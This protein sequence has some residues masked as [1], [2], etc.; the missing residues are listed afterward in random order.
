MAGVFVRNPRLT[1]LTLGLIV[2]AGLGALATMPRQEDPTLTRRFGV[3][4][5]YWPGASAARVESLVTERIEQRLQELHEIAELDSLSRTGV[6]VV[7]MDLAD[8]YGEADVDEIWSKVRDRL[9]DAQR[10][11]PPGALAPEFED[12]TTTALTLLVGFAWEGE[13]KAPVALLSRLAEELEN[14][15]RNLPGTK[16]TELFGEAEEEIR[17]TVDPA[18]LASVGLAARDVAAAVARADSKQPA[19]AVRGA[20]DLMLEV[21]GALESL[22]RVRDVPLRHADGRTLRV[23]DLAAVEKTVREPAAT[24]AWLDGRRGV[25]IGVTMEPEQR[26]DRWAG[27]ARAVVEAF[28]AEVPPGVRFSIV[29]DQSRYTESRLA[30]LAW[31]LL[32]SAVI[33]V[34]V[35]FLMMGVRSALVVTASLPVT[36]ALSLGVLDA[37]G[38]PLHQMSITGLIVAI[39]IL[40]DNAIIAVDEFA[41][42]MRMGVPAPDAAIET[43]RHLRVPLLA[44]NGTTVLAFLPIALMPGGGGEFVGTIAIGVIVAVLASFLLAL[45][46]VLATASYF[47]PPPGAPRSEGWRDH[48]FSHPGLAAWFRTS[49]ERAL[50]RPLRGLAIALALPV[51]GFAVGSTL[52]EQFFPSNDRDQFQIQLVLPSQ[53]SID[54]TRV[55]ALRAQEIVRAH[56]DVVASHWFLGESAPRVYYNQ[57]GNDD[58]VASFAGAIV[59]T[60]SA[61]ATEALLP[62]LQAELTAALPGL[63]VVA[64]PFEQGPPFDAPIE[65]RLFGPDLDRLRALGDEIRAVMAETE[66]VT[67]TTARLQGGEP[68]LRVDADE[69]AAGLQ[70]LRLADVASQLQA[71]LDGATGGTLLEGNEEIPVRVRVAGSDRAAPAAIAATRVVAPGATAEADALAGAPIAAL[72]RFTL[73]PELAGVTRRGGERSNTVQAYLEPYALISISLDDFRARLDA[74]GFRLPSGYR[75]EYGGENSERDEALGNLLAFAVPLFVVMGGLIVLS[76]DSFRM[77]GVILGVAFLSIGLGQLGVWLFG[78]PMGFVAIVGTMGLVGVAIN[79]SILVLS[80]LRDDAAARTGGLDATIAVVLRSTRHVLATTLTTMVGFLPLI[81][82][83]GR[84]W[85]PMAAAIAV[86]VGGATLVALY[87]VPVAHRWLAVRATRRSASKRTA[88]GQRIGTPIESA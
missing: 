16:E 36:V 56:A 70:G 81:V 88:D 2:V 59:T 14:R 8:H 13:G 7:T 76:F 77:A 27:R 66:A 23:G 85:P 50:R 46:V 60:R 45:T 5:T 20:N 29:F 61:D 39:G 79:D 58:G 33:V 11:L 67:F 49:I 30:G 38:I 9:A 47:P 83:G 87:G 3:V 21:R 84:F 12:R 62:A 54:E 73:V 51:L 1:I 82:T 25:A 31:N 32:G 24:E 75:L 15:L 34:A 52:P 10:E 65:V 53:S 35:L 22:A 78:H 26:V 44:S 86:G 48:G 18:A 71:N 57:L 4:T 41:Q 64:L 42:R 19:G 43:A 68:R 72:S 28:R 37:M 63:R 6:S 80:A 55:A 17:I 74:S 69:A 40:I